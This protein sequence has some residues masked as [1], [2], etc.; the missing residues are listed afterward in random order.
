MPLLPPHRNALEVDF[1]EYTPRVSR[2]AS[3]FLTASAMPQRKRRFLRGEGK[4]LGGIR[5]GGR[6][7]RGKL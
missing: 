3:H 5:L 6:D 4:R 7:A 2:G 1:R